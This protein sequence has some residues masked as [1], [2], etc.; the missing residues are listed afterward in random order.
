MCTQLAPMDGREVVR[1]DFCK[2]VQFPLSNNVCRRCHRSLEADEEGVATQKQTFSFLKVRG[3]SMFIGTVLR[4]LRLRQGLTQEALARRMGVTHVF[5]SKVENDRVAPST[6][7]LRKVAF[8]LE[9]PAE[10]FISQLRPVSEE[11]FLL[12]VASSLHSITSKQRERL[13]AVIRALAEQNPAF[14][15]YVQ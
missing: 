14:R 10:E 6:Q 3:R 12:E 13:L 1:C 2:C 7:W 5:L 9:V 15:S 4:N 8:Y 11:G